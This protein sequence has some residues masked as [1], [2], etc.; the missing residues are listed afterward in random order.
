M[1]KFNARLSLLLDES[2]QKSEAG[3]RAWAIIKIIIENIIFYGGS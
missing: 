1:I 3:S 2:T